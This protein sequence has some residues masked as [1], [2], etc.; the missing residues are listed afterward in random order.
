MEEKLQAYLEN[1]PNS[2]KVKLSGK[3]ILQ[4]T[5]LTPMDI[6]NIKKAKQYGPIPKREQI[7]ELEIGGQILAKGKIIKKG[8]LCYFKVLKT[9]N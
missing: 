5:Q 8:G 7:C 3:V 1:S 4:R 2:E 9:F 6:Y